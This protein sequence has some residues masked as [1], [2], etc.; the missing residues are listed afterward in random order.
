MILIKNGL[1]IDPTQAIDAPKDI[2]IKD[3]LVEAIGDPGSFDRVEKSAE[4]DASGKWIVPG[5][6]D[7][8]VHLREPGAE[9]KE[10]IATGTDAAAAGGYTSVFAMPNTKPV[11]DN[12]EVTKFILDKARD[13]RSRV[14]PIGSIS[15]GLQGKEMSPLS[16]LR[17]AGCAAF[18]DDGEPIWS[19]GMMRRALVLCNMLDVPIT[20][21][22]ED[23]FLSCGGCMNESPLSTRLGLKGMHGL[24]EDVMVA[25]DIEIARVTKGHVHICHVS[26]ARGV[27]LIRRAKND[28]IRI[29]AETTPH[30]LMLTED[31]IG[32]YDTNAKMSPP[33]RDQV[34]LEG[35]RAGLADGT[36]DMVASDHA[37]HD[38]DTKRVEFS[39]ASFGIIGLQSSL[40]IALE[41]HRAGLF[42]RL[43]MIECLSSAPAKQFKIAGGS[44]RKGS[45][46]DIAIIDPKATWK[47]EGEEILSISKN[48][49]FF[50]KSFEGRTE[51]VL[52]GGRFVLRDFR[53]C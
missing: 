11:N 23:K 39:K 26:T 50:G 28:G 21:H 19:A 8:H 49:P 15:R 29:T 47:F 12:A 33:L 16:E 10:T 22:E 17:E 30:H 40:S 5:L 41:L 37:P 18:S 2:L 45:V 46:A 1:L 24:A 34:D 7:V 3:G 42:S 9:W 48:T 4:I 13:A 27:E 35:V 32:E 31:A 52:L 6:V 20:C 25:R 51:S 44:L 53:L 43:K 14:Y 36:I 38:L